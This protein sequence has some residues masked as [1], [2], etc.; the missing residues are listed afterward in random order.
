MEEIKNTT[1]SN[2]AEIFIHFMSFILLGISAVA[3]GILYF[4]AINK[5][6][7][8][9]QFIFFDA[10]GVH[11]AIASLIIG[12]PLYIWALW[13]WFRNFKN[14]PEKIELKLTKWLTY[15]VFLIASGMNLAPYSP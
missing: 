9:N 11:Y 15:I 14:A 1:K 5:Y 2:M 12:F 10:S 3:T 13:F 6:F 7:P 8:D 4:Q